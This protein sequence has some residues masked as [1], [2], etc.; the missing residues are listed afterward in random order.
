MFKFEN[1]NY[2]RLIEDIKDMEVFAK[3][4]GIEPFDIYFL[5]GSGCIIGQYISRE[6]LDFDFL[7]LNYS[8]KVGKVFRTLGDFD[9]L[10]LEFTTIGVNYKNRAKRLEEFEYLRVFVLSREDIITSK[11]G[12]YAEKDRRDIALLL[13]QSDKNLVIEIIKEVL[14]RK[15]LSAKI[16]EEFLKNVEKFRMDYDV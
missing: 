12:R 14:S 16:K 2:L 3:T 9:I 5:G 1:L 4:L 13:E 7:D 10:A 11:I 15:D 6:T 8:S